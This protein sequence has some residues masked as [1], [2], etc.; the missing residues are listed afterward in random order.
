MSGPVV[1]RL[2]AWGARELA[3]GNWQFAIMVNW[4]PEYNEKYLTGVSAAT[5]G[6]D[7]GFPKDRKSATLLI[8]RSD[9]GNT[10]LSN[11]VFG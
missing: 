11:R 3:T 8:Y 4:L 7:T 6:F 10:C 9:C 5:C 2:S 1:L